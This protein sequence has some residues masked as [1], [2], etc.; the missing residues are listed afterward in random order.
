MGILGKL[1]KTVLK[2]AAEQIYSSSWFESKTDE[3]LSTLY[4][5]KRQQWLKSGDD[6]DR[7]ESIHKEME[8]INDEMVKRSNERYEREH[9]DAKPA[10]WTDKNR[11]EKD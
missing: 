1:F 3:D 6:L 9:P 8:I 5:E 2:E 4:E 11:W 10:H 7:W